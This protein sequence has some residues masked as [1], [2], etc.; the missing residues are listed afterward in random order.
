MK[1]IIEKIPIS[2][3]RPR[4]RKIGRYVTTYDP[5]QKEK[6]SIKAILEEILIF[7]H[8][9]HA[10]REANRHFYDIF[11]SKNLEVKLKFYLPIPKSDPF[12]IRNLKLWNLIPAN[13]KP[14]LDNLEKFILDVANDILYGD[15]AL[16]TS[17]S[18][19]KYFSENPRTEIEIMPKKDFT[20]VDLK[21]FEM[22]TPTGL[23]EFIQDVKEIIQLDREDICFLAGCDNSEWA[24]SAASILMNFSIKYSDKLR[25][26]A[27]TKNHPTKGKQKDKLC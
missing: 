24:Q 10:T 20:Q 7:D 22:F 18:S 27:L 8:T 11:N 5:Q 4:F 15:D 9:Y 1:I 17:L 26:I 21:V 16:I 6:E 2:K 12:G 23:E 25:K 3:K 19:K 14:D 13:K